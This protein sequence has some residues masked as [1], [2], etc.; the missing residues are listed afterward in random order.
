MDFERGC[1]ASIVRAED[2]IPLAGTAFSSILQKTGS[3]ERRRTPPSSEGP[4]PS[5]PRTSAA[6]LPREADDGAS[7]TPLYP[8]RLGG[9]LYGPAGRNPTKIGQ[10]VHER[11]AVKVL[12]NSPLNFNATALNFNACPWNRSGEEGALESPRGS[13]G[14]ALR[15]CL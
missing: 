13:G 11:D 7:P 12:A 10:G 1:S 15:V 14:F 6:F 3:K 2:S 8:Q 9:R 4:K 5:L